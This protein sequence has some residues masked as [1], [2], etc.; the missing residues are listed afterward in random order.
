M[1][2]FAFWSIIAGSVWICKNFS[3]CPANFQGIEV[4]GVPGNGE[5][6]TSTASAPR[7]PEGL[8]GALLL[9]DVNNQPIIS[10]TGPDSRHGREQRGDRCPSFFIGSFEQALTSTISMVSWGILFSVIV[11]EGRLTVIV[12]AFPFASVFSMPNASALTLFESSRQRIQ[13][14]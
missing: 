1:S 11:P 5:E 6:T 13:R 12:R 7:G 9:V 2:H 14:S 4:T 3:G 8:R 10:F